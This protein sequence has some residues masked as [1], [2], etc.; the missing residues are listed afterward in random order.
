[1][2]VGKGRTARALAA[3]TGRFAVDTDD[4]IQSMVKMKIRH[5][6]DR[7]GEARF[8]QLEQQTADWLEQQV[9]NTIV[10]TGGGFFKVNN[11]KRI[12]KVIFLHASLE[13]ILASIHSHPKAAKKIKKRPLLQNLE[14]AKILFEERLPLYRRVA[15]VEI[16]IQ[17]RELAGIVKEAALLLEQDP[18]RG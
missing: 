2:G 9:S 18:K 14:Q 15:D 13:D 7:Q 8:R 11:L 6:F 17:G 4:L 3:H 10:S 16:S 12:G 1:M 5:I